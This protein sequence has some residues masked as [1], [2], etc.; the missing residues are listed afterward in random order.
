MRLRLSLR[1][2]KVTSDYCFLLN[3]NHLES[4]YCD[5]FSSLSK[6]FDC[7]EFCTNEEILGK[8]KLWKV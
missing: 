6:P 8:R 7:N 5:I 4:F 3:K 1:N 2:E